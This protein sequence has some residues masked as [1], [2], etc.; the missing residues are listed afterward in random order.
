MNIVTKKLLF[1]LLQKILKLLHNIDIE[2]KRKYDDKLPKI[3]LQKENIKN[4][5]LLLNREELLKQLPKNVTIA[6]LGVNKG[7]FSAKI[8]NTCKPKQMFLIDIWGTD[9]YHNG[10]FD[11]VKDRFKDH[12]NNGEVK[13]LRKTSVEAANDFEDKFFDW[14]YIDTTHTYETTRDEL[15]KYENKIKD[16]GLITGHDYSQGNWIKSYRYGV[17]EA[18][19]EFCVTKNWEFLFLTAEPTESQSFAI[20]R[21]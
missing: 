20:R 11:S 21:R 12:I 16:K 4:C 1:P 7:D 19:H 6:E 14:I 5:K 18:V 2:I 15:L 9:R 13:I 3:K 8:I 17:I 10:L